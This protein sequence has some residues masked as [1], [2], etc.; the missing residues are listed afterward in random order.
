ML[1]GPNYY[2]R[3]PRCSTV[4]Y[5]RSIASGNTFGAA[6]WSD[7]KREAPML[8]E[9]PALVACPACDA[10]LWI[11]S[12]KPIGEHDPYRSIVRQLVGHRPIDGDQEPPAEWR[13]ASQ[14][15]VPE[16]KD[17]AQALDAGVAD[18][19]ERE[20][21]LRVRLWWSLNDSHRRSDNRDAPRSDRER[22]QGNLDRLAALLGDTPND[23][24]LRAEIARESGS[25]AR[26]IELCDVLIGTDVVAH[27]KETAALIRARALQRDARVFRLDSATV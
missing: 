19:P 20:R 26:S 9:S 12:L 17:L 11:A 6:Y 8:P 21:Y 22:F 10:Y 15:R 14:F 16:A 4:A 24:L 18:T 25:F 1:P 27:L 3:C 13:T 5:R 2:Y 7:A 23:T